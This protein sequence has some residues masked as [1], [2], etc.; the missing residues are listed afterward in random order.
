M[1]NTKKLKCFE[2]KKIKVFKNYKFEPMLVLKSI[3]ALLYTDFTLC[4]IVTALEKVWF[5]YSA[6][7]CLSQ[8]R[9]S[10]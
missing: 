2:K 5:E 6:K 3:T 9:Q 10:R 8:F 4:I 7:V 1:V